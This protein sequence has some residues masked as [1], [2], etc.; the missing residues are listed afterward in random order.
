MG[1]AEPAGIVDPV[2]PDL[3]SQSSPRQPPDPK[4][5]APTGRPF[6]FRTRRQA[7]RNPA[8]PAV[9]QCAGTIPPDAKRS[10][11]H[12]ARATRDPSGGAMTA[13]S[14]MHRCCALHEGLLI[15][16]FPFARRLV[17]R[18]MKKPKFKYW[19]Y[20]VLISAFFCVWLI[21]M[22][23][24]LMAGACRND[25]YEGAKKLRFCNISLTAGAWMSFSSLE[26]AKGSRIQMER[27]IA[28][29]QVGEPEKAL[30]AVD[31]ALRNARSKP[32]PWERELHQR[33]LQLEDHNTVALW[34]SVVEAAK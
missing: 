5:A 34:V 27:G 31:Q 14:P 10:K 29:S 19:A 12:G 6:A 9:R 15:K 24:G 28:L 33:M 22:T 20:A 8:T 23:A 4:K 16:P 21:G 26:R 25:R 7:R 11:I 17:A 3:W 32:G 2:K 1:A 18:S 30:R 13:S